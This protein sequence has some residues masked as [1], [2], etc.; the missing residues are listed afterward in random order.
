M[1][2][3]RAIFTA[4]VI[5]VVIVGSIWLG[6]GVATDQ[7]ETLLKV[8]GAALLLTCILLGQRIW[9]LYI[10]FAAMH[11]PLMR[12]FS[13][14]EL[15]QA[16]L[17]GFSVLMFMMRR[18]KMHIVF[19]ELDFWRLL[20]A[21]VVFQV[22]IRNPVG[23]NVFGAGSV[24]GKPYVLAALALLAGFILSK[25]RVPERELRWTMPLTIVG[26]LLAF[27]LNRFRYGMGRGP[28]LETVQVVGEGLEGEGAGRVGSYEVLS[29]LFNR[30]LISRISPLRACFSVRWAP[31]ILIVLGL[32]AASGYRNA[33]ANAG[34]LL[35]AGIAYRGGRISVIISVLLGIAA[36]GVLALVNVASPLP[37]R[38]QRA[39]SP[40]PGTWEE[41]YT[42]SAAAST[43]W[44]VEMWKAAL[45]TDNYINNKVLGDGLGFTKEELT[46]MEELMEGG[47][48]RGAQSIG[49]LSSQQESMMISGNY[50]SG[51][52]QTIRTVGYIGLLVMMLAMYRMAV[53]MHR[54][55][56]RC[57]GTEWYPL[58][59]FF[60][61]PII[62]YPIFFFFVFGTFQVAII[63]IFLQSGF[64]D[65]IRNNLT[66]P[67]YAKAKREPYILMRNRLTAVSN[68]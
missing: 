23:L 22:Y 66:L 25:Y 64:I 58:M 5:F 67:P 31:V 56:L 13:T 48:G 33:V 36:L 60:G 15:G 55:I 20:S 51:P 26:T 16:L 47:R 29:E 61:V 46:K 34:L 3:S 14:V 17:V 32:A 35:L 45:L 30:I 10:F 63:F 28:A 27:P 37:P 18:L 2:V 57:R 11:I 54:Q 50:H 12:G 24:G 1:N 40:F 65:L 62:I 42:E 6:M 44:R 49:G 21:L 43:E 8:G 39:L 41:R 9:L 52:V 38:V 59:L 4:F 68:Q 53:H 7:M 19:G